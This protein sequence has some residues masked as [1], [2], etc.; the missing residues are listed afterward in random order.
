[1]QTLLYATFVFVFVLESR[2]IVT[3]I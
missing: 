3:Q 2:N 1:M